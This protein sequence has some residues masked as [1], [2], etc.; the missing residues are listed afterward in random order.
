[1][2]TLLKLTTGGGTYEITLT[3]YQYSNH[4]PKYQLMDGET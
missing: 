1:M 3:N 2:Q 4:Y